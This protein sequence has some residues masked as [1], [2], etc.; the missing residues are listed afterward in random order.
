M[1]YKDMTLAWLRLC[2]WQR[3]AVKKCAGRYPAR[4]NAARRHR[5]RGRHG[6]TSGRTALRAGQVNDCG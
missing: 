2:M 4:R 3:L 5:R 1:N 6:G